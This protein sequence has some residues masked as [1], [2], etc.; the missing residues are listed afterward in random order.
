MSRPSVGGGRLEIDENQVSTSLVMDR[1][2][3]ETQ[4][5]DN[6]HLEA[7]QGKITNKLQDPASRP[8]QA[9][10]AGGTTREM[11]APRI[12]LM[13]T[14][15]GKLIMRIEN[16]II[17]YHRIAKSLRRITKPKK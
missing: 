12:R 11:P 8:A 17:K 10:R 14:A 6:L 5:E 15:I 16:I 1:A 2:C 7:Y 13:T 3:E 9:G 4:P